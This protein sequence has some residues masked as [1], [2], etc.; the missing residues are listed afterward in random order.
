[1]TY[2]QINAALHRIDQL[3]PTLVKVRRDNRR[4]YRNRN[5]TRQRVPS[6]HTHTSVFARS[7]LAESV[8]INKSYNSYRVSKNTDDCP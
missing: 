2:D 8:I 6:L 3:A 5:N 1:M 4:R 7:L